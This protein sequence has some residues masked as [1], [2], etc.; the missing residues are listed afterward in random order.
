MQNTT[1]S[2]MHSARIACQESGW[3]LNRS[4]LNKIL[5][6]SQ[7]YSIKKLGRNAIDCVFHST[8]FGPLIIILDE[9]ISYHGINP[10]KY[11]NF[12]QEILKSN[13]N[14]ERI[15]QEATQILMNESTGFLVYLTQNE[16]GGWAKN[17]QPGFKTKI[18]YEDMVEE[19]EILF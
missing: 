1:N 12:H 14:A 15:I 8:D 7:I 13:N 9:R 5:Y 6:L 16:K 2:L 17:Y 18:Q 11:I 3:K 10:I 4:K 19:A